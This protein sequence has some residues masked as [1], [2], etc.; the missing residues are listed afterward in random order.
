[1]AVAVLPAATP[2]S[3][4]MEPT[5]MRTAARMDIAPLESGVMAK[6]ASDAARSH[7]GTCAMS[8]VGGGG[9]GSRKRSVTA[10]REASDS[11]GCDVVFD[12]LAAVAVVVVEAVVD[13]AF[14]NLDFEAASFLSLGLDARSLGFLGFEGTSVLFLGLDA[15]W[16]V[17]EVCVP[18]LDAS[19]AKKLCGG[20]GSFVLTSVPLAPPRPMIHHE[21]DLRCTL[22][23]SVF[24]RSTFP[25]TRNKS[26]SHHHRSYDDSAIK[27]HLQ[28]SSGLR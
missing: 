5:V 10:T 27:T 3:A 25:A 22:T 16:V 8:V 18:D 14:S 7:T 26:W 2:G 21:S 9:G 24:L 23:A 4:G 15:G 13:C 1:M 6:I 20:S 17:L 12:G 19:F 11:A 28:C